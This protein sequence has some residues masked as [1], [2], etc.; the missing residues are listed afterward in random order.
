MRAL[1]LLPLLPAI[2]MAQADPASQWEALP[3]SVRPTRPP[4][5]TVPD[6]GTPES[7]WAVPASPPP[8]LPPPPPAAPTAPAPPAAEVKAATEPEKPPAPPPDPRRFSWGHLGLALMG[9]FG[10]SSYF[11][12]RLE[13][14]AVYGWPVRMAGTQERARGFTL[15]VAFDLAA[16]KIGVPSCGS[17]GVCGSRYE[18]GLAL[19]VAHNW[20]VIGNDGVVAPVHSVFFQAVPFLSSN[21]V[22][23]APLA[24]GLTWGEHGVRFDV[25]LTSGFLRGSTWPKPG[26]FVIGGGLYFALSLEWLI[27]NTDE[28]GRFRFGISAG[29]GL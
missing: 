4:P 20:G 21:N 14:G 25:G 28:T 7:E 23:S 13:G 27:V 6:A 22:P 16:A 11:A 24:P 10:E 9:A 17:A 8:E 1:T 18:G 3:G 5:R 26:S 29:V 2:A 12:V 19:R 15:G